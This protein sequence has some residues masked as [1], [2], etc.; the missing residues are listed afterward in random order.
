MP[1][2]EIQNIS[3]L[4]SGGLEIK[5]ISFRQEHL[6]R[7]AIAGVSGAGKTTLLKI[8]AGLTQADGGSI[9]F[10]G[11]KVIG[12]LEKLMPGHPQIAYLSQHY[13]L[14]NNYRVEE[15]IWFET[16][17]TRDEAAAI[18]DLCRIGHLLQRRTDQLSGGE[19]QRI[20]TTSGAC[21]DDHAEWISLVPI[22][23]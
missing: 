21:L 18:F 15:L 9:L 20:A 4:L 6:Q 16:K 8:I 13:E 11:K 3:K 12:P 1:Q 17:L 7:I 19:K 23:H 14:L 5:N 2:L 10:D 22:R